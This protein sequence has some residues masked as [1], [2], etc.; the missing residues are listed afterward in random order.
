MAVFTKVSQNDLKSF[1]KNYDLGNLE[2]FDGINEGIQNTNYIINTNKSKFIL[3]LFEDERVLGSLEYFFAYMEHLAIKNIPCAAPIHAKNGQ[4]IF[5]LC[6]RKA[7]IVNFLPGKWPKTIKKHH[8]SEIGKY[9]AQMHLA[10]EDFK[11]SRPNPNPDILYLYKKLQKQG[12]N[13]DSFR[14]GICEEIEKAI[15]YILDNWNDALP[16]GA[17]HGDLFQDNA[18]FEGEKLTGI[19]DFYMA[20]DDFYVADLANT[21][22]QWCFEYN[23]EFNVTKSQALLASYNNVRKLNKSEIKALPILAAAAAMKWFLARLYT[24]FNP[25]KGEMVNQKD[26]LEQLQK[27]RFHLQVENADEYGYRL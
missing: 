15:K 7:A 26:P 23:A 8:C 2:S 24:W 27:L 21:L 6:E 16:S 20:H 14:P 10:A 3:T 1:L 22:T 12:K 4:V 11:P 19:I 25:P 5:D 13:I 17:V 9:S 18:L